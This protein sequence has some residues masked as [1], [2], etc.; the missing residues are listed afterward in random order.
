MIGIS[1][2]RAG[3]LVL[4][5]LIFL[6]GCGYRFTVG[7]PLPAGLDSVAVTVLEN[8]T[9][10]I[11]AEQIITSEL[12]Y[13]FTRNG[14]PVRGVETADGVLSG[15]V[16]GMDVETVSRAGEITSLERRITATVRL[17]LVDG[18]GETIWSAGDVRAS[19]AY[20]VFS[21]KVATETAKREAIRTLARRLAERVY[22]R[23]RMEAGRSTAGETDAAPS[24][25]SRRG[26]AGRPVSGE[27]PPCGRPPN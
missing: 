15:T 1:R 12:I 10:E 13:E 4:I 22:G 23:I 2:S 21:E 17:R 8:R 3:I 27:P 18:E 25:E 26:P 7:G 16:A 6:A 5:P 20:A 19:E 24:P 9:A 11:G 14:H